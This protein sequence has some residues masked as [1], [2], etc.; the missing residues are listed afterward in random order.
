MATSVNSTPSGAAQVY[1]YLV[2]ATP[3]SSTLH[4]RHLLAV[5]T[6]CSR[7]CQDQ[8]PSGFTRWRTLPGLL[9]R[10]TVF[11][12]RKKATSKDQQ[13]HLLPYSLAHR[14][15]SASGDQACRGLSSRAS[16]SQSLR[17]TSRLQLY[18]QAT[19]YARG[20]SWRRR[21]IKWKQ[22]DNERTSGSFYVSLKET[23]GQI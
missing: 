13:V 8:V 14:Q 18:S 12:G 2:Q 15:A 4:R 22:R 1:V 20:S 6:A 19:A 11:L 5:F 3:S 21:G 7:C 23:T 9:F 10:K 16:S 17:C